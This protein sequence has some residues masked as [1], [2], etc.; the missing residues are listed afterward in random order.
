MP[1]LLNN[2]VG[3]QTNVTTLAQLHEGLSNDL[4]VVHCPDTQILFCSPEALFMEGR[5]IP[6]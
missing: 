5:T 2:L 6:S 1:G 3:L 4:P